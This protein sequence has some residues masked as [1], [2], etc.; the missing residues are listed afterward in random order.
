MIELAAFLWLWLALPNVP[1]DAPADVPRATEVTYGRLAREHT[2][3]VSNGAPFYAPG[4]MT[5]QVGETVHWRSAVHSDTHSV[6]EAL[7]G[8]FSLEIPPGGEVSH[9]FQRAGEY[10]YRCRF[11]PW[12]VGR[13]V[14]EPRRLDIAWTPSPD[15]RVV[16]G[17][18]GVFVVGAGARPEVARLEHGNAVR[19]G[20]VDRPVR[21]SVTPAVAAD[22]ALWFAGEASGTLVRFASGAASVQKL[23]NADIGAIAAGGGAIW[24][25]DRDA[26]RV[27]RF[28][29]DATRVQWI[30]SAD[31]AS[32]RAHANVL[33]AIDS[34]RTKILEIDPTG[35]VVEFTVPASLGAPK[36]LA[37]SAETLW[38]LTDS[39]RLARLVDGR[40]DDYEVTAGA[41]R[42]VVAGENGELWL[43]DGET[44]RIGHVAMEVR[45]LA[46]L[47]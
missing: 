5:V 34:A 45:T 22:G 16:A 7:H 19:I 36:A 17:E 28:V 25:H 24:I 23:A 41:A 35:S 39:G 38:I 43:L 1:S 11:H 10:Q 18:N 31:L 8:T 29:D 44:H 12:M 4:T 20:V 47:R 32:M 46:R 15:G 2:I 6:R 3:L 30:A 40:I 33:W 37:P 26:K 42:D 27:G 21:A 9:Q 13:I 14:V